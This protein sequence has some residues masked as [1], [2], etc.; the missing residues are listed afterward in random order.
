MRSG[1]RWVGP[2][3]VAAA[4]AVGVACGGGGS[5]RNESNVVPPDGGS[6][7]GGAVDSGSAADAGAPDAGPDGGPTDGGSDAGV[8]IV[9]PT[10]GPGWTFYG[11]ADGMPPNHR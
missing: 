1:W 10:L 6:G 8:I 11:T 4:I 9:P 3:A 2:A 5:D 7:D